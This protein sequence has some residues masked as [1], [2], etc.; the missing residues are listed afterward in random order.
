MIQNEQALRK[1]R[2]LYKSVILRPFDRFV[3]RRRFRVTDRE[4]VGETIYKREAGNLESIAASPRGSSTIRFARVAT[5]Y[6]N[7]FPSRYTISKHVAA[8]TSKIVRIS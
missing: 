5:R 7:N 8:S 1:L 2:R 3:D 4:I 6:K